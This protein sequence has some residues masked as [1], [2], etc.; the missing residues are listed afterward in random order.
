MIFVFGNRPESIFVIF[1]HGLDTLQKYSEIFDE[2]PIDIPCIHLRYL[3][4]CNA[5]FVD[6]KIWE[7]FCE[8]LPNDLP[9]VILECPSMR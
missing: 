1:P 2:Q 6:A 7:A 4:H 8:F 3:Y 5:D 9:D